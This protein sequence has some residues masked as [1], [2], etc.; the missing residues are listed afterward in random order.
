MMTPM[1]PLPNEPADDLDAFLRAHYASALD[2]HVGRA[3]DAF[4]AHLDRRHG[5]GRT[6]RLFLAAGAAVAAGLLLAMW[7]IPTSAPTPD[8][9]VAVTQPRQG[10]TLPPALDA[11]PV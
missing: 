5:R 6:L 3:A 10:T 9:P 11:A 7:L 1:T 4:R 2:P 8:R